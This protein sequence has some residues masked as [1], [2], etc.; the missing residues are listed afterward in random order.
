M[1]YKEACTSLKNRS[2]V[3]IVISNKGG[4]GKTSIAIAMS[5]F[6]AQKTKHRTLLLELDSSPGDFKTIFDIEE[7]K[8][9]ELALRFPQKYS[10]YVKN[11]YKNLDVLNGISNPLA[12]ESIKTEAVNILFDYIY[13]DYK[14]III[15]TQTTING[16]ILD[17]LRFSDLIFIVSDYSLESISRISSLLKFLVDKFSISKSKMKV[18]I[19]K[20]KFLDFYK[21]WDITKII[22]LPIELFISMDTRFSKTNFLFNREKIFRTKFFRQVSKA[23]SS[24]LI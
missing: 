24:S 12:A 22:E 21:I 2:S 15:D 5:M 4:V 14:F 3:L 10:R 19:N 6:Y 9:L 16:I 8:S 11:I 23:I 18:I 17:A 13:R 20:K 7:D 1:I